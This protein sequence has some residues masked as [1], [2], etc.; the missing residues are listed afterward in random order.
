MKLIPL[1]ALTALTAASLYAE[2]EKPTLL[3]P[4]E[5]WANLVGDPGRLKEESTANGAYDQPQWLN[6]RRFATTRAYIQQDPW[7]IGAEHWW[8]SRKNGDNWTHRMQEEIEIGLPYRFQ[9]DFYYDWSIDDDKADYIDTAV[10][11]R[12]ALA[13]WGVIP[14]NPTLYFEYKFTDPQHGGDVIEPKLLLSEEL[15]NGVHWA[16]NF[17]WE[18]ELTDSQAEE[19]AFTQAISKS[20]IDSKLSLGLEMTYKWETEMGGRDNPAKKFNIGPSAQWRPTPNSHIDV[21]G[22]WGVGGDAPDFEGWLVL[23]WNFGSGS[24]PEQGFKPVTRRQ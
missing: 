18:K 16:A 23:G 2:G 9:F 4:M 8:R 19:W 17:V 10:E 11:V 22:L 7:E 3:S 12:W 5:V 24:E 21:V 1:C 6:N 15:G 20:L 14:L 13:N